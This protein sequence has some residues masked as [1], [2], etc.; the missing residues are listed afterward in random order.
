[1]PWRSLTAIVLVHVSAALHHHFVRRDRTLLRMLPGRS[2]ASQPG[3]AS[4]SVCPTT[5]AAAERRASSHD[6]T[7]SFPTWPVSR[8][9]PAVPFASSLTSSASCR[10]SRQG[11]SALHAIPGGEKG[12]GQAFRR[13]GAGRRTETLVA[14]LMGMERGPDRG[15]RRMGGRP[16]FGAVIG[17]DR[18][19]HRFPRRD[20]GGEA[21]DPFG[22]DEIEE[23]RRRDQV[24]RPLEDAFEVGDE[25]RLLER[26]GEVPPL[27]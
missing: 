25:I 3:K 11:L 23:R 9:A 17:Q 26:D 27:P 8:T 14:T 6:A 5:Q 22:R 13:G 10:P 21:P 1:M 7:S 19:E 16:A 20:G 4:R 12:L 15:I 24:G 2:A 18:V